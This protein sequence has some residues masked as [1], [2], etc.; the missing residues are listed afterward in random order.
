M[1]L[2]LDTTRTVHTHVLCHVYR[3]NLI[4]HGHQ[5]GV[6]YGIEDVQL[7]ENKAE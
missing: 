4:G 1:W 6:G 7:Q 3:Q 5:P 2:R